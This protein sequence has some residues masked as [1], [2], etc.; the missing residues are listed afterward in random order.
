VAAEVDGGEGLSAGPVSAPTSASASLR[1]ARG[2]VSAGL[3]RR[4]WLRATLLLGAP[5]AWFVLLY[6]AALVILFISAFWR[7]DEFT[8]KLIHSWTLDNFKTLVTEPTYRTIAL[9]TIGIAA[10]VTVTDAL[11][12]LPFAY[13]AARLASRRM[14]SLL[15]V[16]VLIPLWTSY[17]VRVYAWRLILAQDGILNWA[18]HKL[19][20]GSLEVAYS[21]WAMWIVFSYIW[22]PFM[23]LPVWLA[24]ERVPG[25]LME[26]SSD[27]GARGWTTFRRVLLPMVLP[28]IVAGSIFTFSLTLG[29]FITPTLVGGAGS[30]FIGNVVYRSVGIA[31]NVPFAAAFATIPLI[32]MALYLLGARKL[33]AFEAM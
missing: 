8:G 4:A 1:R 11:L 26:A 12:A 20:L 31:S 18:L 7:V 17:L 29:D 13:F 3:F 25:S 6:I 22:L 19:G 5:A 32:V 33:G 23:I 24:F 27:L 9:R 14:Q 21:N 10:A 30:D 28:G 2:R 15:F 16:I